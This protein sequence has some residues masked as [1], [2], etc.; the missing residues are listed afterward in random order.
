MDTHISPQV[1]PLW[2]AGAPG[3]EDWTWQ[4]QETVIPPALKVVRNVV[5]PTL[6]AYL[7]DP[8]LANGKAVIVAPG[9]AFHFLSIDMEGTDVARWLN[10]RGIAAFVLK[11]RLIHTGDEFPAVVWQTLSDQKKMDELMQR[12][13]PL[14]VADGQQAIRL[15]RQRVNEWHIKPDCIGIMGFSAGGMVTVNAA[16]HYDAASRPDFAAP[17]YSAGWGTCPIPPDAPPLFLLCAD[18]DEMATTNSLRLYSEW[19]AAGHSAELHIYSKGAHGFGMTK[20][21]LPS[22]SWIERF[23]D[24]LQITF[25]TA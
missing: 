3:S 10:T 2:P 24:W 6:T 15:V 8:A 18:D 4:E 12:L 23:A 19:K 5:Q 11:Y 16:L 22:D 14:L 1:I 7:P 20:Q 25:Q 13:A 9:G 21:G 17:I